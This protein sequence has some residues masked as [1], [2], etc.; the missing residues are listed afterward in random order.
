ML[1]TLI[2]AAAVSWNEA[3]VKACAAPMGDKAVWTDLGAAETALSKAVAS[4]LERE[5]ERA[6]REARPKL[7]VVHGK[8]NF[9]DHEVEACT[10]DEAIDEAYGAGE[11]FSWYP[12][13]VRTVAGE[14][15]LDEEQLY[16]KIH[17]RNA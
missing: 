7:F 16:A 6:R 4:L 9:A 2:E 17:E 1:R 5:A 12:V 13:E 10:L 11:Y 14:L 3:R 15:V 8:K